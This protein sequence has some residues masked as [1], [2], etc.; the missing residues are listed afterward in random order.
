MSFRNRIKFYLV[1][2][3]Q[4]SNKEA[5]ELLLTKKVFV[6]ERCVV[7]NE[8]ISGDEE[9]MV[10]GYIIRPRKEYL[11]F[12]FN[13]PAGIETTLNRNIKENLHAVLEIPPTLVLSL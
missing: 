5:N 2:T 9:I 8:I 6:N 4:V 11:Y 7:E 1:K 3:L 10:N 12:V 13:K